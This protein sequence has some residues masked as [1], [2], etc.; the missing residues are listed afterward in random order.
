MSGVTIIPQ[1]TMYVPDDEV[2]FSVVFANGFD[3][4][5]G[6]RFVVRSPLHEH[7]SV[8][9][10]MDT[11]WNGV[12][13]PNTVPADDMTEVIVVYKRGDAIIESSCIILFDDCEFINIPDD[14]TTALESAKHTMLSEITALESKVVTLESLVADLKLIQAKKDTRI[15][16]LMDTV[17]EQNRTIKVMD[18]QTAA[19]VKTRQ[20]LEEGC[21]LL[22]KRLTVV[23]H[24]ANKS[25]DT[26][27]YGCAFCDRLFSRVSL[28][29]AHIAETHPEPA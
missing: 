4:L 28:L 24:N 16:Q 18:E 27:R 26:G 6:D 14:E 7:E 15:S 13:A 22:R 17:A 10:T 1:E 19:D 21:A 20:S 3:R 2:V 23:R 8:Y 11:D 29:Q 25:K 12:L 9:M 5:A